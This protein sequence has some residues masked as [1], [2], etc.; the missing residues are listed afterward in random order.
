MNRPQSGVALITA[1]LVVSLAGILSISLLEQLNYDTQRTLNLFRMEQSH[2][3]NTAAADITRG[4]LRLDVT[5]NNQHD[6]L[7]EIE[8][9]NGNMSSYPVEGGSASMQ[10][11]DRQSCFNLNSVSP[12]NSNAVQQ[13][14]MYLR[15]LSTLGIDPS[16]RQSLL[17]SLVDWVDEDSDRRDYGAEYGEY[18]NQQ[19]PY[20]SANTAMSSIS[21]LRLIKG[22]SNDVFETLR[23]FVCVRPITSIAININTASA[24][25]IESVD[26]LAGFSEQIMTEREGSPFD[27]IDTFQNYVRTTLQVQQFN[28]NG[29]QVYSEYFLLRSS[30][31]LG[32]SSHSLYSVIFRDQNNGDT[33]II[34][35][36]RDEL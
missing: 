13:Q 14:Q 7:E 8:L 16:L 12:E 28:S 24:E 5:N 36:A 22:Y 25:V 23:P 18:L 30:T 27:T 2:L 31:T 4:L 10:I 6:T 26:G 1:M 32:N 20:R 33:H 19:P 35:Q 15:L 29:I 3:Y 17:D 34:R 21:E 9:F 11:A